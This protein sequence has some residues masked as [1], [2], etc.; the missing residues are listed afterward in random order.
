MSQYH[1]DITPHIVKQL[2]EQLVS[3]EITALLELIKNSYDAD[4]SYVS[5]EINTIGQYFQNKLFYTKHEGFIVV[6]DDG[7]GMSEETIMKSWLIISYSQKRAL[8]EAK[9]KTPKG[10]TPLGDKGLGRLSTQR[11]ADICEIFTNEKGKKGSHIA[12]N[13]KDFEKEESLGK[14]QIQAET[15]E[16][17]REKGTTLILANLNHSE[18]WE[19]KNLE[20]FK[21]LISEIISPYSE[22]KPFEVFLTVN[23]QKIELEKSTKELD[24]LAISKFDFKFKDGFLTI[25]G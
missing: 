6:E 24:D 11:L 5:I 8:K 3:D 20:K 13:W 16:P 14:V 10:R 2:G 25:S 22:S 1:F 21:G 23:N 15:F 4:A 18:V 12:F 19:G 17:Q 7:F 9:K